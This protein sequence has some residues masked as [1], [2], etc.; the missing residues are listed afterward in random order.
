MHK[1]SV[2]R[3]L[4][5]IL[6]MVPSPFAFIDA[7]HAADYTLFLSLTIDVTSHYPSQVS[8]QIQAGCA[9]RLHACAGGG[10]E[11]PVGNRRVMFTRRQLDLW[12]ML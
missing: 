12:H 2:V 4:N 8:T 5:S 7:T 10:V 3:D 6:F 11:Y 9:L 1:L